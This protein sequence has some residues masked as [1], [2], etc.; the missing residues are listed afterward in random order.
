MAFPTFSARFLVVLFTFLIAANSCQQKRIVLRSPPHYNFAQPIT[1]KLDLKLREISGLAWDSK[2]N[3]FVTHND[4]SGKLFFLDKTVQII[5]GVF[6][7]AGKADYEDVALVNGVPYILRSDGTLTRF[8]KDSTGATHGEE[9]GKLGIDGTNDFETLYYDATRKA[10]IMLCKNCDMDG[11]KSVSAFAYYPDS[12][13][14]NNTPVFT[15]D[16]GAV[17]KLSPRKTS[18]LQPSAAAINPVLKKLF[19]LSSASNQLVIADLDGKV[20]A[21]YILSQKIFT[22]PEGLTFKNNGDMYISN[23][24]VNA[25]GTILGFVYK[26]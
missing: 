17:E 24:G 25:K 13:G 21:V 5:R 23:E 7:F 12:I 26:P 14:W 16:A 3:E 2:N 18:K 8:K 4:E 20:E 9:V 1:Y 6:E 10:L 11:K 22:Q 15:I 19:I